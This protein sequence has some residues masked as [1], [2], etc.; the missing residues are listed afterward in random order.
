MAGRTEILLVLSRL[1][2]SSRISFHA[3][4]PN[5]P[6]P[7]AFEYLTNSRK[8]REV[9]VQRSARPTKDCSSKHVI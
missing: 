4:G 2:A 3:A 5:V 8:R 1:A 9:S 6:L 7:D